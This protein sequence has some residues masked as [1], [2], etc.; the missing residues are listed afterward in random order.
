LLTI[1]Y[2]VQLVVFKLA[3]YQRKLTQHEDHEEAAGA[4]LNLS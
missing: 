3:V 1:A 4:I 2:S